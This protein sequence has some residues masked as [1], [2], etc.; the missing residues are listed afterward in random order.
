MKNTVT[1]HVTSDQC[2]GVHQLEH[3]VLGWQIVGPPKEILAVK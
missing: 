1:D 2:F 3:R